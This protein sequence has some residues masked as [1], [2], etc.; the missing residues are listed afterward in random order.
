MFSTINKKIYIFKDNDD[1]LWYG[2]STLTIKN[3]DY[4]SLLNNHYIITEKIINEPV[5]IYIKQMKEYDSNLYNP[6]E[7]IKNTDKYKTTYYISF[8]KDKIEVMVNKDYLDAVFYL[9]NYDPLFTP[10]VV[11]KPVLFNNMYPYIAI[12]K[13]EELEA[14]IR[15]E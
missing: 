15:T 8:E 14:Y 13:K 4:L 7:C 3:P 1:I 10:E 9:I 5:S 2:N 12:F 6:T 11:I